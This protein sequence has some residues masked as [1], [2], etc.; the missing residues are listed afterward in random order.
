[1]SKK[2]ALLRHPAESPLWKDFDNKHSEFVVDSHNI[3]L[4]FA[5][6]GFNPFRTINVSYSIWPGI[7]VPYNFPPLMCMKLSNFILSIDSWSKWTW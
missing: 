5:T 1:M 6:D 7:Y 3:C 4:A 2:D